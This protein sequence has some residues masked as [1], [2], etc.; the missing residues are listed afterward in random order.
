VLRAS[1]RHQV[2][3]RDGWQCQG[4][5][6]RGQD[7]QHRVARGMGGTSDVSI[8]AGLANLVTLCRECHRLCEARD[9]HMRERGLWLWR[10]QIPAREPVITWDHRII[11]L[12]DDGSWSFTPPAREWEEDKGDDSSVLH[13]RQGVL[14]GT[15][16]QV[17][18]AALIISAWPR[19][20]SEA[21]T[22]AARAC[23]PG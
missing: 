17:Q 23:T 6:Q 22:I 15:R 16:P 20:Q 9:W 12:A 18:E 2:L 11:W 19:S 5:G 10:W 21:K 7:V 14:E 8:E 4:C 3:L 13:V 1:V